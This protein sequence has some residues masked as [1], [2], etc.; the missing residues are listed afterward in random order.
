M[1]DTSNAGST[2]QPLNA[3]HNKHHVQEELVFAASRK[4]KQMHYV[5]HQKALY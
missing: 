2:A 1:L 3:L 5:L 4:S